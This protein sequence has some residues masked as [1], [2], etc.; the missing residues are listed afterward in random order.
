MQTVRMGVVGLGA[1]GARHLETLAHTNGAQL[2][3]VATRSAERREAAAARFGVITQDDYRD[4][5]QHVD[6]VVIA[7][8]TVLHAEIGRFFLEQ[9]VHVL[10]EKP[11]AADTA[12]AQSLIDTAKQKNRVL[13]VGQSERFNPAYIR[14][15]QVMAENADADAPFRL[16]AFRMGPYDGRA[17]DVGIELDLMIHDVDAL[18]GLFPQHTMLLQNAMGMPVVTSLPDVALARIAVG[19]AGKPAGEAVL[20]AS[21]VADAKRRMLKVQQGGFQAELDFLNQ[22]L[23]VSENGGVAWHEV[24]VRQALPLDGELAHF[25]HCVQTAAEPAVGGE[26]GLRALTLCAQVGE[27]VQGRALAHQA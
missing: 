25:V 24:T 4:L 20:M 15:Q 5:V 26:A 16:Q 8:P 7:V 14:L 27:L 18:T 12:D 21:R 17:R 11:I 22:T 23:R 9:G 13:M 1:M 19:S 2:T 10:V 6:A 3:A